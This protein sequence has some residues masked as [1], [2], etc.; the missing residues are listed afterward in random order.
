MVLT[1]GHT[2][3]LVAAEMLELDHRELGVFVEGPYIRLFENTPGG[4]GHLIEM[5]R[6]GRAWLEAAAEKLTGSGDHNETCRTACLNCILTSATQFDVEAGRIQRIEALG[7]LGR[8]LKATAIP[9]PASLPHTSVSTEVEGMP[10]LD[11]AVAAF[12]SKLNSR[13]K[14]KSARKQ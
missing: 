14:P 10:P 8:L 7:Y 1:F 9:N 4:C 5:E 13:V 2:L 6:K 11:G 12:R 3:R